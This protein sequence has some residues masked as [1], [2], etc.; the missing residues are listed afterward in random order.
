MGRGAGKPPPLSILS[1]LAVST[2][3]H[4]E[5]LSRLSSAL[6]PSQGCYREC[7][8]HGNHES[9]P[10]LAKPNMPGTLGAS[11]A[12][13]RCCLARASPWDS[14]T[15]CSGGD[16]GGGGGEAE[17]GV[18]AQ[19]WD[20]FG[21]CQTRPQGGTV[22]PAKQPNLPLT[23]PEMPNAQSPG[24]DPQIWPFSLSGNWGASGPSHLKGQPA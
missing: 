9:G 20:W 15:G 22:C 2:A 7:H 21:S 19:S 12:T 3:G 11:L 8:C 14:L 17:V 4:T 18:T 10:H 1:P 23:K 13:E 6:A 24:L 5:L 16:E